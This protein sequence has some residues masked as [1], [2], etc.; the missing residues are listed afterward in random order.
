LIVRGGWVGGSLFKKLNRYSII[1]GLGGI[2]I[3]DA[4]YRHPIE[5]ADSVQWSRRRMGVNALLGV[6]IGLAL[7]GGTRTPLVSSLVFGLLT[8]LVFFGFEKQSEVDRSTFPNQGIWRSLTNSIHF[9]ILVGAITGI[10]I[11]LLEHPVSGVVNGLIFGLLAALFGAQG[12]G[13]ICL[14]HGVL[15]LLLWHQGAVPWRYRQF[16]DW[17]CRLSL[18]QRVGGGYGFRHRLLQDYFRTRITSIP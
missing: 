13:L 3:F 18:L 12:S 1:Y 11:T 14:K 16:L 2:W 4:L 9:F 6:L 5:P 15:R 7:F 17:G 10:L 8:G